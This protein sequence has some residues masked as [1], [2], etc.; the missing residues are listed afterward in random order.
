M[1]VVTSRPLGHDAYLLSEVERLRAQLREAT[2]RYEEQGRHLTKAY[3]DTDRLLSEVRSYG[4]ALNRVSEEM[5]ALEAENRILRESI[6]ALI[7]HLFRAVRRRLIQ[8]MK[9][10]RRARSGCTGARL[11][12]IP[13]HPKPD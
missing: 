6:R 1:S 12:R 11:D 8:T 7:R 5:R 3:L 10:A 4:D 2:D 13:P 9:V